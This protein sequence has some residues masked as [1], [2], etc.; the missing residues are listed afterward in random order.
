MADKTVKDAIKWMYSSVCEHVKHV[1]ADV[2]LE[3]NLTYLV[4]NNSYVIHT[5]MIRSVD[6]ECDPESKPIS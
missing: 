4:I 3:L 1:Y 5:V 6:V 2:T